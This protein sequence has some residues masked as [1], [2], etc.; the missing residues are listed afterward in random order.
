MDHAALRYLEAKRSVDERALSPRVRDRLLA[1]LPAEPRVLEAGC[2]TGVT[3]A[4]LREWDVEPAS[5]RGVDRDAGVVA[6]ARRV[7]PAALRRAGHD[8]VGNDEG[9]A[10]DGRPFVFE[11]G[12]ALTAFRDEGDADLLVAQAFADLVPIDEMLAAF[13]AALRPGGLVYLP[14]TFDGG[15]VFQPD[16]PV[17]EAVERAY[18]RAID[19][20]PGRDARAGRHLADLLRRRTGDLLAMSSSD[21][22]VRPRDGAYPA[23]EAHFLARILE[24]V[25]E[26]LAAAPE[27]VDGSEAW[28]ERRREQLAAGE[29][30][31]VAHQYDLLYRTPTE[32]ETPPTAP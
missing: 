12:D 7:R 24:F 5:Y 8:A 2:G 19:R 14:I 9:F 18:H 1:E 16:H 20:R 28:L 26:A 17:D 10:V 32:P 21:W 4:R 3:V 29:L 11:E 31:Y 30:T 22:I 13:E 15:T 25:E 23:D 6:F 27:T